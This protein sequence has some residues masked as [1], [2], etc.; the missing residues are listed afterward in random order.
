[1]R[2]GSLERAAATQQVSNVIVPAPRGAITD[3]DG[4]ELAISET[5][6]DVIGDPYLIKDPVTASA[7][8]AP[9]LGKAQ[10]TVLKL[11]TK[12]R[13]GFVYLAH[14]LPA[15]Q[16]AN[17][18][19]LHI[20]GV[21][22][23]PQTRRVYPRGTEAAQVV[24]SVYLDGAGA[25]GIE[26]RY[27]KQLSGTNGERRIVSDAI[28]Q[29][30]SIDDLRP[31]VPGKTVALTIDS[32]LQQQVERVLA[33]VGNQYS[34]KSATAIAVDPSTG[35][36]LAL[37]NWRSA[38]SGNSSTAGPDDLAIGLSY[39][40]GSTFKAITVAGALQDGL[41]T[42]NTQFDVPPILHFADRNISDA[43]PHGYETLTVAGILKKS[44]NIGADLIGMRLGAKRFDYW[45]RRFG[46]GQPTGVDLP[47]EQS[48]IVLH[49]W[50][51][52]GSSMANL[53][54]GQGES[55][56]PMQMI[57]AY[58]AIANGG[59]LRAPHVVQSVGGKPTPPPP[60][61][62]IISPTTAS[63]LRDMLRGVFADGGTASGAQID[64]Y[65]MAGKTGTA[66]IAIGGHYSDSA[67]VASF[68][69][70][71]PTDHPRLLVAVVVNQPQ[72]SIFGGSVAAPAFQQIVGWA[73]PYLGIRPS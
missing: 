3:R 28:G 30:I 13:T 26:Y 65:D 37:A 68:I 69:G 24:G 35:A 60:G 70:M 48:G 41:V 16:S 15:A 12:P 71:V 42:P 1:V 47:G 21:T 45:V 23:A 40:P 4:A 64:G 5:A 11:L 43:E 53:P 34:P 55:V 6:D 63:Q 33:Q 38:V 9:L 2:A 56:T 27:D 20:A 54:F 49:W 62:R 59:I 51:Y 36:I 73:V 66:N 46:F 18:A 61:R 7:E 8:L 29:A 39:E 17:I 52:S 67:Y 32:G 31:T 19:N 58:T 44:S 57:A 25:S 14:L 22:L 10:L 72:G 50:N